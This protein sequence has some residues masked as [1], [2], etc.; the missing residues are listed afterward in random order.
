MANEAKPQAHTPGPWHVNSFGQILD[1]HGDQIADLENSDFPEQEDANAPLIAA[2]PDLLAA[3]RAV[4]HAFAVGEPS[5]GFGS[6]METAAK[7]ARAAIAKA[8]GK[9]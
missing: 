9:L 3:L 8:D 6:A 7:L 5:D 2:A 4:E 1:K